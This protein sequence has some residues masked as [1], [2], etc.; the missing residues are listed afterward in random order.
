M[1]PITL[2]VTALAA[3]A[4]SAFKSTAERAVA[5]AYEGLKDVIRNRYQRVASTVEMLESQP[6]S[7]ARQEIVRE[8]LAQSEAITDESLLLQARELLR[9]I[10]SS[11]VEA[12]DSLIDLERIKVGANVNITDVVARGRALRIRDAEVG[13]DLNLKG[14]R[15]AEAGE[16][17]GP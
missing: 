6:E 5:D 11:A 3:G 10:E 17:S 12:G 16:Q 7:E 15:D 13:G 14:I 4:A 8:E 9:Q 2:I 1:D